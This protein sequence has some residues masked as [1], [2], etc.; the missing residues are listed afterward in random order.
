MGSDKEMN[1]KILK[2]IFEVFVLWFTGGV[3]YFYIEILCRGYSHISMFVCAGICFLLVGRVGRKLCRKQLSIPAKLC[4]VMLA[5]ACIIT[6][7]EFVTG[8]LVNKL[9]KL[10]VWDYSRIRFNVLGQ[11]CPIYTCL[12]GVVSVMGVYVYMLIE[13]K[14]FQEN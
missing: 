6:G 2:R 8:L 3:V 13:E 1:K 10:D 7:L 12:W 11:I 5:G 4:R 14:I 9:L